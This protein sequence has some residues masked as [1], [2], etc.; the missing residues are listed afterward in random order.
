MNLI[1]SGTLVAFAAAAATACERAGGAAPPQAS[2]ASHVDTVHAPEV[3]LHRFREG[4]AEPAV[5]LSGGA[6]D[7]ETLAARWVDAVEA[8]DTTTIRQLVLDRAEFAWVYYPASAFSRRPL[9]QP[10]GL[11]WFRLQ[12]N[13]EK[14][15]TRVLRRLGGSDM[16]YRGVECTRPPRVEGE[17]RIWEYCA[18]RRADAGTIR[19]D[20]LFGGILERAGRFKFISYGN[21]F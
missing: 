19:S 9:Y 4:L 18:V 16:A 13:S 10:P 1:R 21:Q 6:T 8:H 15:I 2:A 14:G 7:I 3:A 20:I 11:F 17:N 12:A 5:P